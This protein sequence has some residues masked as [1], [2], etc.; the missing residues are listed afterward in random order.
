MA[1]EYLRGLVQ[2][3]TSMASSADIQNMGG[4][5]FGY[6]YKQSSVWQ[7]A[8]LFPVGQVEGFQRLSDLYLYIL[9]NIRIKEKQDSLNTFQHIIISSGEIF[10]GLY[11]QPV[12][13]IR[14]QRIILATIGSL[15]KR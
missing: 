15:P 13:H 4:V 1:V 5:L 14:T 2:R 7:G 6:L 8:V 10:S 9:F 12:N 3:V 11:S